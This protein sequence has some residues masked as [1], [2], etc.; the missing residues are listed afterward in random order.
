MT[1]EKTL[2]QKAKG[3]KTYFAIGVTLLVLA[4]LYAGDADPDTL[5]AVGIS[6]L[7]GGTAGIR[8][9]LTNIGD[10]KNTTAIN[11]FINVIDEQ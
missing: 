4:A 1:E 11:E 5:I 3:Y 9:A 2:L 6:G 7:L 10:N 8:D